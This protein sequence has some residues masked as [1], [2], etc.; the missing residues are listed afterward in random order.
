MLFVGSA[1]LAM[2]AQSGLSPTRPP[3]TP[4]PSPVLGLSDPCGGTQELLKK[5][6]AASPCVLVRGQADVQ[7]TYASTNTPVVIAHA[8]GSKTTMIMQSSYSFGYPG[9][10]VDV[11]VTPSSQITVVLPSFSQIASSESGTTAG[12]T[13]MEFRYKQLLYSDR[14]RGTLGGML[15]I[16]QAPTGSPGLSEAS[17][18]YEINPLLNLTLNKARSLGEAS[19]SPYPTSQHNPQSRTHRRGHGVSLRRQ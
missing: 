1:I 8:V 14:K 17:P 10:L 6:L 5:Y 2:L 7:V 11:G 12:A 18:S 4:A 9:M 3:A 13:D 15:L 16:Y 19:P